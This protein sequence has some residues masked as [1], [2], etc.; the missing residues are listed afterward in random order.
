MAHFLKVFEG[1]NAVKVAF[2]GCGDISEHHARALQEVGGEIAAVCSRPGSQ[3]PYEFA[4]RFGVSQVF[5][6]ATSLLRAWAWDALVI[7][8]PPQAS[9]PILKDAIELG[10]PILVEKPVAV[11]SSLLKPFL[12]KD[13]PIIVGYNRR[14][15]RPIREVRSIVRNSVD[16]FLGHL[17]LP[18]VVSGL[19]SDQWALALRDRVMGNSVHAL[20]MLCFIF[21]PMDVTH[22]TPLTD[23]L[24]RCAGIAATLQAKDNGGLVQIT[25]AWNSPANI[26]FTLHQ[27]D[28]RVELQP[29]ER[30]V[31]YTKMMRLDPT[32][33]VP[34][35]R[36]V[37]VAEKTFT[38]DPIDE[39][40]KPGMVQQAM[41]LRNLT[42][43]Q[44]SNLAA[45]L[46]DAYLALELA[47]KLLA[48][49]SGY[50]RDT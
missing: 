22:C 11:S 46:E 2:I 14:F 19:D 36:Y 4:R 18:E 34:L 15:Y 28:L 45:T 26:S 30:A 20:D 17:M 49:L 33:E 1:E 41:A 24:G 43:G 38:I 9:L 23:R 37:P 10:A 31:M 3:R 21:G 39:R 48:H 16:P 5:H 8:V 13:L 42:R 47:E 25:A 7:T 29:F 27:R 35:R 6:D 32:P 40:F 50:Y 44:I 12:D